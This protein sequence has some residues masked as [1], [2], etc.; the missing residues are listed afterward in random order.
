MFNKI[1]TFRE[2]AWYSDNA[3]LLAIAHPI[4]AIR[5]LIDSAKAAKKAI[6]MHPLCWEMCDKQE[7]IGLVLI[8]MYL[9]DTRWIKIV[10]PEARETFMRSVA[11]FKAETEES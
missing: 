7:R 6:D 4:G 11:Q 2:N 8:L 10:K 9:A 3:A 5:L 1:K